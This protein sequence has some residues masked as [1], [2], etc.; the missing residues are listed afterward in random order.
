M[1]ELNYNI[2]GEGQPL[3]ILHGLF[4]SSRN[5]NAVAKQLAA[6]F[7]VIA[8]DLRNHGDSGH[9]ADM[10]YPAMV[11]DLEHLLDALDLTAATLLG[12]SMGGKAA[13]GFALTSPGRTRGLMVVDIA[14]V[15]YR[16]ENLA[17]IEAMQSLPLAELQSRAD[18]EARLEKAGVADAIIRQFLLQNLVRRDQGYAWRLNLEALHRHLGDL[19]SFPDDWPH[20]TYGGPACF[21]AGARSD[22]ILPRHNGEIVRRFPEA[23]IETVDDAD[24][25]VHADR[26]DAVIAAVRSFMDEVSG[27]KGE[28]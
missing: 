23:V 3:L 5:W 24:H 16:P 10:T 6:D 11:D 19:A 25:W 18:A 21:L 28:G 14:P 17:L 13:M 8:V 15:S 12:H 1:V 9:D 20:E 7:R 4:G 27:V 2:T 26:P 22:Y